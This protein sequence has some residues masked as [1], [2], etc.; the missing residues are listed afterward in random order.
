M[1]EALF[2]FLSYFRP[3]GSKNLFCNT[4]ICSLYNSTCV[5]LIVMP[6]ESY[7]NFLKTCLFFGLFPRENLYTMPHVQLLKC[8]SETCT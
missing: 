5:N 4:L 8:N 1:G 3:F 7:S 2:I 6:T